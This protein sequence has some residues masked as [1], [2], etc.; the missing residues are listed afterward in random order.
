MPL[1]GYVKA[2]PGWIWCIAVFIVALPA[3]ASPFILVPIP[4]GLHLPIGIIRAFVAVSG[5]PRFWAALATLL[6]VLG[7]KRYSSSWSQNVLVCVVLI[8]AWA[9]AGDTAGQMRVF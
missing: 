3:L 1:L 4:E 2:G 9:C 6:G 5:I 8:L 7:S